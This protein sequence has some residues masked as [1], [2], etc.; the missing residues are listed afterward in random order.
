MD[1]VLVWDAVPGATDARVLEWAASESRVLLTRDRKTLVRQAYAR[2]TAGQAMAGVIA[3]RPDAR[4]AR[5]LDDLELLVTCGAAEDFVGRVE[6][7][8]FG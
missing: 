1:I 5:V 3:I 7:L 4:M 2:V 6:F 8:P